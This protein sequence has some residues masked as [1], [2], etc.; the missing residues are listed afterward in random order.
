MAPERRSSY[1]QLVRTTV[2]LR[3]ICIRDCD[4][5]YTSNDLV[6]TVDIH[7][8]GLWTRSVDEPSRHRVAMVFEHEKE[9]NQELVITPLARYRTSKPP[10][11]EEEVRMDSWSEFPLIYKGVIIVSEWGI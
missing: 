4:V 7:A 8:V 10:G 11:R 9:G 2:D 5:V 3:Q 1:E 6:C